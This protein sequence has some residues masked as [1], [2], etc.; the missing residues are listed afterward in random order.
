MLF[1]T[2]RVTLSNAFH[3]KW[4]LFTYLHQTLTAS[5]FYIFG[6]TNPLKPLEKLAFGVRLFDVF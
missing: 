4:Y 2:E 5:L 6:L 1:L 3:I